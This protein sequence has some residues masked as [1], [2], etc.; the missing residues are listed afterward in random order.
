MAVPEDGTVRF[1]SR[2][3]AKTLLEPPS[4]ILP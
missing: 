2:L 4:Y 3:G 1:V